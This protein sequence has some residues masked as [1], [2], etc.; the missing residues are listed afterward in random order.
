MLWSLACLATDETP[1]GRLFRFSGRAMIR[2]SLPSRL[3]TPGPAQLR[4]FVRRKDDPLTDEVELV[5]ANPSYAVVHFLDGMDTSVSISY[6]ILRRSW[7]LLSGLLMLAGFLTM[8]VA[9]NLNCLL[10]PWTPTRLRMATLTRRRLMALQRLPDM[11][12]CAG[13]LEF[14]VRD[15]YGDIIV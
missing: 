14:V 8:C 13:L 5:E 15:R 9:I 4:R 10:I 3:L 2:T 12:F 6:R 1:R 11:C 7:N